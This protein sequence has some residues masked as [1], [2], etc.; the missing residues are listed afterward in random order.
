MRVF[1]TVY[2]L[3]A[4]GFLGLN[5][6]FAYEQTTWSEVEAEVG[7]RDDDGRRADLFVGWFQAD[8]SVLV[9]SAPEGDKVYAV[10]DKVKIRHAPCSVGEVCNA[11]LAEEPIV[12]PMFFIVGSILLAAGIVM[13][14]RAW[15]TKPP[16]G[17]ENPVQD[18]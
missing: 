12:Q 3:F 4:V 8:D 1:S 9:A 13:F 10:G 15:F 16:V 18:I 7:R 6:W 2:V 17:G 5:A 11:R 14:Y